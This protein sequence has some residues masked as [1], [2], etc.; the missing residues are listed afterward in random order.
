MS[1]SRGLSFIQFH[2]LVK[3]ELHV[4]IRQKLSLPKGPFSSNHTRTDEKLRNC[5]WKYFP[6]Q[7][8]PK[9]SHQEQELSLSHTSASSGAKLG[10][11]IFQPPMGLL[12][13]TKEVKA[14]ATCRRMH[15]SKLAGHG[16]WIEAADGAPGG[17]RSGDVPENAA[18]LSSPNTGNELK[19]PT[20]LLEVKVV[21]TCWRMQLIR[22]KG[23]TE[24]NFEKSEERERERLVRSWREGDQNVEIPESIF[25]SVPVGPT[26]DVAPRVTGICWRGG[27]VTT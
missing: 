26:A 17:G 22:S 16:W 10:A 2:Y 13:A 25:R 1:T 8:N 18:D 7:E 24:A 5:F 11:A 4:R 20:G 23:T 9:Q 6:K 21:A 14:E 15:G 12:E 3:D 27:G 19:L